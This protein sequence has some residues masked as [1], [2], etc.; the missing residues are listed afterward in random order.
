MTQIGT[1]G[2]GHLHF[3]VKL[4]GEQVDPYGWDEGHGVDPAR[5][6]AVSVPLW[7]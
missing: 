4:Y 5:Q 6:Y 2:S 1:V 7:K 3:T